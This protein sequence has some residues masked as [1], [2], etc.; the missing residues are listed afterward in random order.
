MAHRWPHSTRVAGV[1]GLPSLSR[2]Q[3]SLAL[4]SSVSWRDSGVVQGSPKMCYPF[5]DASG[6]ALQSSAGTL[7]VPC[8]HSGEGWSLWPQDVGCS[9]GRPQ[10]PHL[11]RED[12]MTDIWGSGSHTPGGTCPGSRTETTATPWV[13]PLMGR[14]GWPTPIGCWSAYE[15]IPRI[16]NGSHLLRIHGEDSLP[17]PSYRGGALPI[18]SL[19]HYTSNLTANPGQI[20]RPTWHLSMDWGVQTHK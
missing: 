5:W 7:Q 8:S 2:L 11:G 12:P 1:K 18:Q 19:C 16:P 6:G 10:S 3:G 15:H 20:L 14:W 9:W 17:L 13:C 4:L